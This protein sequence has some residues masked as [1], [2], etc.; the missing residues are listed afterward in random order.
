MPAASQCVMDARDS[1]QDDEYAVPMTSSLSTVAQVP[2]A[3]T[4][5]ACYLEIHGVQAGS[6]K[7]ELERLCGLIDD[8]AAQLM[9]S[10]DAIQAFTKQPHI[11][12]LDAKVGEAIG[13]AV[14][15]LQFQDMATQL[16]GHVVKR[17]VLLEKI[18][19]PLGRLSMASVEELKQ[20]VDSAGCGH[21]L[22]PV[23]QVSMMGGEVDLF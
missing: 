2:D 18:A 12:E 9:A 5:L 8:A 17:M 16:V 3:R 13:S 23:E 20:A 22:G 4:F 14:S 21:R 6:A 1:V 11:G 15:A 10:F 7:E 19:E